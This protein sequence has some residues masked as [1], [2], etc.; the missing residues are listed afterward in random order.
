MAEAK[1]PSRAERCT[2]PEAIRYICSADKC[3]TEAAQQQFRLR[4]IVGRHRIEKRVRVD[5][6]LSRL[7][8]QLTHRWFLFNERCGHP[9]NADRDQQHCR[10]TG[11]RWTVHANA[12]VVDTE[13]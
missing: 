11:K 4:K 5:D 7:W 10:S 1:E 3:E 6:G 9:R 2:V 8:Q 13:P 12:A